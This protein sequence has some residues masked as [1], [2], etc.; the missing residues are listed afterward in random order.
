MWG[1]TLTPTQ[2]V[3]LYNSG[4]PTDPSATT[5]ISV[6]PLHY[7]RMGDYISGTTIPDQIGSS[8]ITLIGGP[9]TSTDV[10]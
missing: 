10:P 8:D 9:S 5:G 1:Y 4:L 7:W 2:V 3:N 6:A